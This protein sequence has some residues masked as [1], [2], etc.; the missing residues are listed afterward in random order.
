MAE[1][2]SPVV[3]R[4]ELSRR[5][6]ARRKELGVDVKTITNALG[7]TRNYW[8]AVENDRTLIAEDKLRL[9]FDVLR[10][11]DQ[12]QSEL[13]QLREDSRKKGW[14]DRHPVLD[15]ES[16]RFFG[17]ESGARRLRVYEVLQIP[18]LLQTSEYAGQIFGA[19]P[20]FSEIDV[21]RSI[22]VRHE[23]QHWLQSANDVSVSVLISEAALLQQ[24]GDNDLQMRQLQALADVMDQELPHIEVRV[25]PFNLYPGVIANSST[26][27]LFEF[28]SEHLPKVAWQEAIRPLGFVLAGDEEYQRLEIAWEEAFARSPN[29]RESL[30]IVRAR[31]DSLR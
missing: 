6:A 11:D 15:E 13:L 29:R 19:D 21:Q 26:L 8:S 20:A 7:F 24:F 22:D 27:V 9:L 2:S 1:S 16:R 12:D 3:A 10:F 18:G 31:L 30:E 23:R 28:A 14:W 4:W 25:L 17:L 5:L